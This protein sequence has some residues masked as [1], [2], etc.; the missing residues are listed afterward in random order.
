MKRQLTDG[1]QCKVVAGTHAGKSGFV[2]DLNISK[3]GAITITVVQEDGERFKALAKN[4]TST[5]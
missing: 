2:K 3:T 4:V 5:N 1:D